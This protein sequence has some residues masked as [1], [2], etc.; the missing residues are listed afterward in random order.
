[1]PD[2]LPLTGLFGKVPAHGDFVRRGLPTSFVAPWDAWLQQGMEAA[3]ERLGARWAECWDKAPPWRFAL[4]PG[5]CGPD[6]V[7][8]VILPSQ[9]M[10]G[11]RFP[12]TLVALLP[13]HA[14]AP[15]AGWF[16]ALE[17]AALAGRAGQADA[18][19]LAAAIPDPAAEL[20]EPR[21]LAT[22]APPA[23]AWPEAGPLDILGIGSPPTMNEPPAVFL[24]SDAAMPGA[25]DDS[26]DGGMARPPDPL[27][28]VAAAA[29]R[30]AADE[31]DVLAIFAGA[32]P[33]EYAFPPPE[34]DGPGQPPYPSMATPDAPEPPDGTL[35]FLLGEGSAADAAS[36]APD[37]AR[38]GHG[39]DGT[40]P[41]D[42]D[43]TTGLA[44][45]LAAL[46]AAGEAPLR[47]ALPAEDAPAYAAPDATPFPMER[48]TLPGLDMPRPVEAP[49]PPPGGGWWTGGGGQVPP[50]IRPM[51]ALLPAHDFASLLEADA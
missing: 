39:L 19:A 24:S 7:A 48:G 4:P 22:V 50:S 42:A 21:R 8:G 10:V 27:G 36:P 11:R 26:L 47:A 18:D 32:G 31:D 51:P 49:T 2:A 25:A 40:A 38:D 12:I 6:A 5:A 33:H 30:P 3:R 44:D 9:D 29:S 23:P 35:A 15:T 20:P 17:G 41:D 43:D 16:A 37:A 14:P 13:A 34:G 45:P 1:M 46:I 28:M